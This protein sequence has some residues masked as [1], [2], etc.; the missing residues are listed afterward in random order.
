M[1]SSQRTPALHRVCDTLSGVLL[2]AMLVFAPWAVGCTVSWAIWTMCG[3]GYALGVLL[4]LKYVSRWRD[5]YWPERWVNHEGMGLWAVRALAGMT[6]LMLVWVLVSRWNARADVEITK[7]G[8]VLHY[9]D[10]PPIPWLPTSYDAGRTL[11]AF[12]RYLA[13]ALTFWAARDW[14]TTKSRRE[15][16]DNEEA[17]VP[18]ARVRQ[19]L[20]TLCI[21]SGLLALV[22]IAQRMDGTDK[23]LWLIQPAIKNPPRFSGGPY[24]YRTNG[25]QY[26]N[27]VWPVAL[28]FW[29]TLRERNRLTQKGT[30]RLG[31]DSTIVLLPCTLLLAA[32]PLISASR[33]GTLIMLTL[34]AGTLVVLATSR[35]TSNRKA[36]LIVAGFFLAVLAFG[37]FAG[38]DALRERFATVFEDRLSNRL[39]LYEA[40]GRMVGDAGPLGTGAETFTGLFSLY[41]TNPDDLWHAFAHNDWLET[42]ITFGWVGL[43]LIVVMLVLLAIIWATGKGLVAPREYNFLLGMSLGGLLVHARFDFPFQMFSLIFLFLVLSA[44]ALSTAAR[45]G[46]VIA[47]VSRRSRRSSRSTRRH[48]STTDPDTEQPD[49]GSSRSPAAA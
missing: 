32:C 17:I 49:A 29:W 44:L 31:S 48:G 24:A 45:E 13:L 28:A 15:R 35:G 19:L 9:R 14:I 27:L 22:S 39:D 33:G 41:R 16:K 20:W 3:A 12:W 23:L 42:R 1:D 5:D 11:R 2:L 30:A 7:I 43:S 46:E 34:L 4:L 18:T 8:P 37:W 21:S 6:V 10:T 40:A 26:F 25:A 38:G 36:R 47:R